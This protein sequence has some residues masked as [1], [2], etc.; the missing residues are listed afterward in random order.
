MDLLVDAAVRAA[1][2]VSEREA[3][4]WFDFAAE[5][6]DVLV[7]ESRIERLVPA[8]RHRW[9]LPLSPTGGS[10]PAGARR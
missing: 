10:R 5:R 4:K 8:P 3:R 7:E 2:A 9:L 6:I 1:V